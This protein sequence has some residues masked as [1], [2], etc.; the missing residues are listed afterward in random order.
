MIGPTF[1]ASSSPHSRFTRTLTVFPET[2]GRVGPPLVT[3]AGNAAGIGVGEEEGRS[4]C[5]A[6]ELGETLGAV[7]LPGRGVAD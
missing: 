3:I 1:V 5:V 7:A 2:H 4:A 6:G